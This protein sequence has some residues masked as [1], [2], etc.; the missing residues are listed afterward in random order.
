[1]ARRHIMGRTNEGHHGQQKGENNFFIRGLMGIIMGIHPAHGNGNLYFL[2]KAHLPL[3][4]FGFSDSPIHKLSSP[5]IFPKPIGD[6]MILPENISI[7]NPGP[8]DHAAVLSVV[9]EW[10][11]GRDL[12]S[13]LP[14]L[15]FIHFSPTS[16]I[17]EER[18]RLAGFLVGF[19]S[20]SFP[21]EAYIH[22][23][24]VRPDLRNQGLARALYD[25]FFRQFATRAEP[26][27]GA[28]PPLKTKFPS[29]FTAAWG[30]PLNR[31]IPWSMGSLSP[32][33][34][35]GNQTG[36]WYS[37]PGYRTGRDKRCPGPPGTS[38]TGLS[39]RGTALPGN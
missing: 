23:A 12:R 2:F 37:N 17:A 4:P 34:I 16:F 13:S 10:W 1:M 5:E 25:T 38:A 24:G 18:G 8:Q 35:S 26:L 11:G 20:Q 31:A 29:P 30:F 39:K 32:Q 33:D 15:L 3:Y 22:F 21:E 28:A 19:L 36:R 9:P 27:S 6:Q 14:K 7:R